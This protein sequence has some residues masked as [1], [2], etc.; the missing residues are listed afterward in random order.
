MRAPHALPVCAHMRLDQVAAGAGGSAPCASGGD[1]RDVDQFVVVAIDEVALQV[2]HIGEAAG[3]AGA[4]V[5]PGAAQHADHAA[6]HVF[7]AVIAGAFDHRDGAG[8]AHREALA[9][10]A[11]REQLAAGGAVQAG[12]AD[13]R[14][15]AA[16]SKLAA[17]RRVQHQLAAGHALADVVVGVAFEVQVQAAGI[18]HAEAL[19]GG[20]GQVQRDGRVGHAVVAVRRGRSRPTGARRCE[21]STVADAA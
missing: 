11:R 18:P 9:G 2:E 3:D 1:A 12:V 20:A 8:I 5:Q 19:A 15:V 14:R 17:G 7:A 6:G 13:D 4:E 16:T 10:P 21:R